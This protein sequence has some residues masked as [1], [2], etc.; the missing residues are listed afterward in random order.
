MSTE[1]RPE[2]PDKDELLRVVDVWKYVVS[3][4]MHF[5]DMEMKIRN[6]Y[7]TIL[8]A[9]MG[10]IGVVQGKRI[11][12]ELFHVSISLS[13]IVLL[14]VMPISMLFYFM[15]RHWY[16]RLLQGSVA[17]CIEI[18]NRYARYLPEMQLGS[19]I[20]RSSPVRFP[21][22]V[23][24]ILFRFVEDK[25]FWNSGDIHS[26]AKIEILYKSVI[27][28]C[29]AISVLYGLVAGVKFRDSSVLALVM[30]RL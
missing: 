20:S 30:H 13:I 1:D 18:E 25:R 8:A 17:Q 26:D 12:I 24:K 19:H 6:L 7:F 16:H 15:D 2:S 27:W 5:N 4:E 10:L 29:L 14:A 23:W 9:A 3:V 22:R 28:G 21:G 11:N